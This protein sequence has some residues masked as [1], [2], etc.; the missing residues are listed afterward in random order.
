LKNAAEFQ[1]SPDN[2]FNIFWK[3]IAGGFLLF[4][5][6]LNFADKYSVLFFYKKYFIFLI[7][8]GIIKNKDFPS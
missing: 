6:I 2:R 8:D 5:L 3:S 4:F 7:K 1:F